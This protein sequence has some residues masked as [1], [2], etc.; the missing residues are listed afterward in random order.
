MVGA[1]VQVKRLKKPKKYNNT[2]RKER[3][4]FTPN[5][6]NVPNCTCTPSLQRAYKHVF[7]PSDILPN[8]VNSEGMAS[9]TY[10][11]YLILLEKVVGAT[12]IEPVT[13]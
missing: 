1:G 9:S 7:M 5:I 8:F 13:R 12:G 3:D 10:R 4:A 11:K 2:S 6:E